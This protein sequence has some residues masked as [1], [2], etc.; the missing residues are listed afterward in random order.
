MTSLY[1]I[2]FTPILKERVWG[3]T[4]LG[5]GYGKNIVEGKKIGES[6]EISGV[7]N[8][9]SKVANGFLAGNN[10]EEL[11][12]VYM[13]DLV[14]ENIFERFGKEF[15]LLI[16]LIDA[17]DDLSVQVHP[18]DELAR[19]R[20]HAWGKTEMWYVLEAGDNAKIYTGFRDEIS[21]ESFTEALKKGDIEDKLNVESPSP[22]DVFFIPAGRIHAIGKGIVLAEIQQTSDV[23][24]RVWDWNRKG[25][26]GKPRDLHTDLAL[27][28]IDYKTYESYKT[29]AEGRADETVN[30]IDCKYFT[31]NIM[32]VETGLVKDYSLLDSFVIYIC[33]EGKAVIDW[34]DDIIKI[35]KGETILIPAIM[36]KISI[37]PEP[38]AKI[39]EV[40]IRDDYEKKE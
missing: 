18:G 20:H 10:L 9:I 29:S 26:D 38:G 1:P 34:E 32:H 30:I 33:T 11:V 23:T 6:W 37:R 19:E 2:K 8:D 31:S 28:A 14:G 3:G 35:E 22:G 39:L 13:G 17:N 7:Q 16:K 40:Y 4:R 21:K 27:D 25:L 12:E 5:S 15:P 24:Y 36:E